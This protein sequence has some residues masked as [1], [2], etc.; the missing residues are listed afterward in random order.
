MVE[1]EEEGK[2]KVWAQGK[3]PLTEPMDSNSTDLLIGG[4][5]V[6]SW[7]RDQERLGQGL[8][9]SSS[10]THCKEGPEVKLELVLREQN[11]DLLKP[12]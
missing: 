2:H 4:I 5:L 1:K 3:C 6:S 7:A 10:R 11:L 9:S 12:G 8:D